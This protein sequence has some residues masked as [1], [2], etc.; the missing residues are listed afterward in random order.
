MFWLIVLLIQVILVW[1]LF[2]IERSNVKKLERRIEAVERR[3][4]L[5]RAEPVDAQVI[6]FMD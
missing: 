5:R 2:F 4:A 1:V 6:D 3:I